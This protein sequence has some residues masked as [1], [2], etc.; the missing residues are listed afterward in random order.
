MYVV[1]QL[2]F[3]FFFKDIFNSN[4]WLIVFATSICRSFADDSND[5]AERLFSAIEQQN[6]GQGLLLA[7]RTLSST[8]NNN[9]ALFQMRI[10]L[11]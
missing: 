2:L 7:L 5:L 4:R 8:Q 6:G 1:V 11:F 9:S 3:L 10:G